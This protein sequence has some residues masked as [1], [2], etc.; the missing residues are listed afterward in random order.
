MLAEIL[1]LRLEAALHAA[2]ETAPFTASRFVPIC[3]NMVFKR[4]RTLH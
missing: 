2:H 1:L 3:R 4:S